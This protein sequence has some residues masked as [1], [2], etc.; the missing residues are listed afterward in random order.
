[1]T[2]ERERERERGK[3]TSS[4]GPFPF[5]YFEKLGMG[6]EMRIIQIALYLGICVIKTRGGLGRTLCFEKW[7]T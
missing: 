2:N 5:F 3:L 7:F 1:M 6:L 4:P